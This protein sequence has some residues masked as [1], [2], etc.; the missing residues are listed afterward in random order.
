MRLPGTLKGTVRSSFPGGRDQVDSVFMNCHGD[1][2]SGRFFF[3]C[4][5][6]VDR[7]FGPFNHVR[8]VAVGRVKVDLCL[9]CEE[10]NIFLFWITAKNCF[11]YPE[12]L[13]DSWVC[14]S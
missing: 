7:E 8:P 12:R 2:W 14:K 11:I 1:L 6:V 13:L 3:T 10:E 4:Y 5:Q 9:Y